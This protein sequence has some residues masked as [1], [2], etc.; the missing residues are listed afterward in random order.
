MI[1]AY[2]VELLNSNRVMEELIFSASAAQK[3]LL[4][5]QI[6]KNEELLISAP[7]EEN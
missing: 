5:A 3:R 6:E 1:L 2:E 7:K 4:R